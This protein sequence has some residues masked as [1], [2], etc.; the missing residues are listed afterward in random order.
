[1]N[2]RILRYVMLNAFF[3]IC[4]YYGFFQG[5]EKAQTMAYVIA[6]ACIF[7]GICGLFMSSNEKIMNDMAKEPKTSSTLRGFD[8][9]FD[10]SVIAV[11]IYGDAWVTAGFYLFHML[12]LLGLREKVSKLR[13]ANAKKQ[14]D[15][16]EAEAKK[17]IQF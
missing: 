16:E 13:E 1:M 6:W 2:T 8:F 3:S 17:V 14:K 10:L 5:I 4:L 7:I 9:I 15:I 12:V 11:F